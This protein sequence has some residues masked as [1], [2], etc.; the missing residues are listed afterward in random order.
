[1][2]KIIIVV[3]GVIIISG[4]GYWF[5]QTKIAKNPTLPTSSTSS[6]QLSEEDAL[7]IAKKICIKGEESLTENGIYNENSK[8]WW[9]DASLNSTPAG[10]NPACVVDAET[11]IAEINWRC[12]GLIVPIIST[13]EAIE[14]L[15]ARKYPKYADT[16]SVSIDKETENHARGGVIFVQGEPGGIFLAAKIDETWQIVFDGN[17]QIPCSLVKYGFPNEMLSDCA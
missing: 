1:M 5:Y 4:V 8:T 7:V 11:K 6:N 16:I 2:K 14:D 12:T 15:F 13:Q 3:I 9:F 10:C 17:G